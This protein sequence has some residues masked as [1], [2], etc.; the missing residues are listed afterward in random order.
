MAIHGGDIYSRQIR[1]DFSINVN[2]YGPTEHVLEAMKRSC[3]QVGAY[4]DIECRKLKRKLA[5]VLDIKED[6]IVITNG[7][8]EAFLGI[9][10]AV[11]PSTASVLAPSFY[12][13]T[14]ALKAVGIS[15]EETYC[16]GRYDVELAFRANPNNPDGKL[17]H[18]NPDDYQGVLVVDEC[19]L[20]LSR[21]KSLIPDIDR[22]QNLV[23]V[24]SFTKTFA[25][26]HTSDYIYSVSFLQRH[27]G[28][29]HHTIGHIRIIP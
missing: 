5:E 20:P 28:T 19:F 13:Y 9:A 8:S 10:R 7:A 29:Y 2:P 22:Y 17:N 3:E 4:P 26:S 18:I 1:L 11:N 25:Y 24:R 16:D 23:V 12:G 14:Y 27:S 6:Y 15:E 21:G